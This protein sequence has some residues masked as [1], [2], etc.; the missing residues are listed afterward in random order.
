MAS[1][2]FFATK[3]SEKCIENGLKLRRGSVCKETGWPIDL[4]ITSG[5]KKDRKVGREV[6]I[7]YLLGEEIAYNA[8][9]GAYE[10]LGI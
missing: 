4:V 9:K 3:L 8:E 1:Y 10:P 6:V 7:T 2:K 5:N